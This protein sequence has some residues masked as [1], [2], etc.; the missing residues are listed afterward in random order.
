MGAIRALLLGV[1]LG[2]AGMAV[3]LQLTPEEAAGRQ[4]YLHGTSASADALIH[5]RI[6]AAGTSMPAAVVPCA[7]CHGS[8]GRGRREGGVR[9]PDITWRRLSAPYGQVLP[10]GRRHPA[11]D[12]AAF[13]R[14]LVEGRDPAG[15]RLDP[16]MPR[17]VMSQRDMANL[18]AYI[19]RIEEDRDPG[20]HEDVVRIGTLLPA[21]GP[22]ASLG[23][24]VEAVLR[25]AIGGINE[26]GGVH[27][28]RLE[29]VIADPGADRS[30]AE[31]ALR[32]LIERRDVFALVAP[33]APVLEGHYGELLAPAGVPLI[34]PLVQFADGADSRFV[35]EPLPGLRE[36]LFALAAYADDQ[37]GMGEGQTLI[38]YPDE[39]RHRELAEMLA[40]HLQ[41]RGW[42]KVGLMR[43][44]GAPASLDRPLA[45]E[46]AAV[47]FLGLPEAFVALA[48]TLDEAGQAPLL[49][50]SSNQVAGSAL[51]IPASF[52][53][54]LF[55]A[56]PFLPGDWTPSGSAALQAVRRR[57]G[58]NGQH[59]AL[60][61]STYSA[62]LVLV[63]GLK[64][65]GRDASREKLL[66]A[67]ENLHA[68]QT[69][70]TPELGFGPGRRIGAPGAHIVTV[71]LQ[72]KLFRPTG[73]Y[74]K[75]ETP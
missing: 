57:G 28:R 70:V 58:L 60:Q 71:D 38:A 37:L 32:E 15:N 72:R 9:P 74:L 27:G 39:P 64:R 22:L 35:F 13:A 33:L 46:L 75:V 59:A 48:T 25:G 2:W 45:G 66:T 61:V 42:R 3:A 21:R 12:E 23:W 30:S 40:G 68:F 5:A 6:G 53:G 14:A 4:I 43:Y 26:T 1:L 11:Y 36:Q 50:A 69:G 41:Q 8:D 63:E 29:L 24:T 73:R 52:S 51:G 65:A 55:L 47:F 62:A 19:K 16:A 56:Y 7:S 10:S 17:F 34:G 20:L 31:A 18:T 54:R 67:L 49:F 44:G